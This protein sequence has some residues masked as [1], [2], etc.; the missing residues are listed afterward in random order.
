MENISIMII[1]F[2]AGAILK[3]IEKFKVIG[4]I[5][6]NIATFIPMSYLC[7]V[8]IVC[9]VFSGTPYKTLYLV[10][11]IILSVAIFLI[12]TAKIWGI[13]KKKAIYI[14]LCSIIAI[15]VLIG[16]GF[17]GYEVYVDAIPTLGESDDL[18]NS[19]QPYADNTKVANLDETSNFTIKTDFPKMDGATALYPVYSAFAKAVYP[20]EVIDKLLIND[21]TSP[22]F[23]STTSKAY[24]RIVTGEADIIFVAGPSK[25]QEQFAKDNGVELIYTPIGK[26]AFVFFVNSKNP[27]NNITVEQIQSIY[28]G[29][30]TQWADLGVN[31]LGDIRAFQRDEGSGS[32]SALKKIM[33]GK[34][35][36][37]PPLEDR[38]GD[39]LSIIYETADYKNFKNA[40]GYSF[41]F[42][43]TEMVK[44]D[45]IKLLSINGVEPTVENIENG[46]YPIASHFY[47]VTRSNATDNTKALL[48][49]ILSE[50][51]QKLIERTGYTP[52]K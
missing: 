14:P 23:C 20:K 24:K 9:A 43:S 27:L 3:K 12:F 31:R 40:I 49:W 17:I 5:C 48:E 37:E 25:E 13:L 30:I 32:Q 52:L 4:K 8:G 2:I 39:M 19:Y 10:L 21:Q 22:L 41:R 34:E 45:M 11:S 1:L 35:L 33:N 18:L 42:Y 46:T 28:S 51:G 50:Q 38:M 7:L 44:N 16:G 6:T 15:C 26:E 29:E 36:M 47:A